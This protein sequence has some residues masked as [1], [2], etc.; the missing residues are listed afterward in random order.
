MNKELKKDLR[1]YA[2]VLVYIMVFTFIIIA[3][4]VV[5]HESGHFL[6]GNLIGCNDIEIIF[7]D[8]TFNTYTK[9]VCS[10]GME[11][12][13]YLTLYISGLA[14]I[15]PFALL[16][17]FLKG[18]EKYYYLV[19]LGFNFII[20]SSDIANFPEIFGYSSIILGSILLVY[21]EIMLISSYIK[22]IEAR[23]SMSIFFSKR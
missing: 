20:S 9:M 10:Q 21:G 19:V 5:L 7:L 14:F 11:N 23:K 4:T 16:L 18:Y 2:S 1:T 6:V 22:H 3:S 12:R 13:L 8:E 15:L 17:Y